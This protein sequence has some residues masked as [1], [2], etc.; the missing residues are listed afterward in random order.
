MPKSKVW[1]SYDLGVRGDY[2]G[3][4]QFLDSHNAKEAG[5]ALAVLDYEYKRMLPDEL[6]A[7]LKKAVKT[8]RRSRVYIIYREKEADINRGKFIIGG[9]KT[10]PWSGYS[11][12]DSGDEDREDR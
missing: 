9:R 12:S 7:E 6:R 4:Y 2:D 3:M 8:D 1:I 11:V 10:P 5:D